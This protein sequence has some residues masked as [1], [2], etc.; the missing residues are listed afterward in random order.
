MTVFP[1]FILFGDDFSTSEAF[2]I[3]IFFRTLQAPNKNVRI[4]FVKARVVPSFASWRFFLVN[5]GKVTAQK[6]LN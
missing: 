4:R 3:L 5:Q 6:D 1:R 2:S